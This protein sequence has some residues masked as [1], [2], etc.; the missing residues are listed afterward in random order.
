VECWV[1]YLV[2]VVVG[3]AVSYFWRNR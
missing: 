1:A 2:G 3:I